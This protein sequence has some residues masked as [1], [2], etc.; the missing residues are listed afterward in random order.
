MATTNMN[1]QILQIVKSTAQ[2]EA[3]TAAIPA[4]LLCVE[5]AT[6]GKVKLKIGNGTDTWSNLA[7][8]NGTDINI[9]DY[10][11]SEQ[12][13]NKITT[14]IQSLGSVLN[15]KGIVATVDEL[16]AEGNKAGDVYLVGTAGETK[17][18]YVEYVWTTENKWEY[19]GK[20][21]T[22]M[23]VY[24]TKTEVNELLNNKVDKV[25]GK[26]LSTED[27]AT[28]YKNMLDNVDA[29]PTESSSNFVTSGGV[30]AEL[31]KKVET[32]DTLVLNC[33]LGV[34]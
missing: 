28:S 17:D 34:E 7:Y 23:S 6:D 27:F 9:A 29:T 24:Y 18:S 30:Y 15:L 21:E 19:I 1:V 10:Y 4:K 32:T 16:P 22:D 13:D 12:T 5:T 8:V 11:T 31:A 25:E 3:V 33:Q 20:V 2:W 26:G 14:A